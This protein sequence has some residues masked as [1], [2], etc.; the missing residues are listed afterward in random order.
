[1]SKAH[2]IVL[3]GLSLAIGTAW[4]QDATYAVR[5]LTPETALKAARAA[6]V[7]CRSDGYQVTVAVVDRA[8][9]TQVVLRDRFA[10]PHTVRMAV[11]KAWTAV[12]F[13][14]N[15]TDLARATQAGTP[16]S[17]IRN[18]PRVVAGG[19]GIM[20]EGA[21]ALLGGIGVSGAPGGDRD[22]ECARAG[23]AAIQDSLD[24]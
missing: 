10:G 23:I 1:M 20:I 18:R 24:F 9:V 14:T 17:A 4:A 7:K 12:S 15:T 13:R 3:A 21:G 22:D 5:L 8:G 11:D 2:M 19:G 6:L 16:Q